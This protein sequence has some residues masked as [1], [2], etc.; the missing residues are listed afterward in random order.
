MTRVFTLTINGEALSGREDESILQVAREHNIRI[1]TLCQL[2]GLSNI[3]ACRLCMVEV[4]GSPKLL[5]A[6][7]TNIS[8]GMEVVTDSER[9]HKY[10]RMIVEMLFSEGNHVCSVCVVNGRCELQNLA[11][12]MGIDQRVR[13]E[14][15]FRRCC[16]RRRMKHRSNSCGSANTQNVT[17]CQ[18]L[19]VHRLTSFH[20]LIPR[21]LGLSQWG[22]HWEATFTAIHR[23]RRPPASCRWGRH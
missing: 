13:R 17:A 21:P 22:G 14:L 8:E 3:G 18:L 6:C 23:H 20:F 4:V 9:L 11:V 5:S 19:L 12:R 10:R 16:L 1:P 15:I 2:E 7:T